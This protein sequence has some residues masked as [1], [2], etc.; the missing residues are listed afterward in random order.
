MYTYSKKSL[1]FIIRVLISLKLKVGV[2]VPKNL[3]LVKKIRL[4]LDWT[5][6]SGVALKNWEVFGVKCIIINSQ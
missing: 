1:P 6:N 2:A 4:E 3:L 5:P